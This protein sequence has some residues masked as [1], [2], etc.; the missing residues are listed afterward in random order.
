LGWRP[1]QAGAD[2]KLYFVGD[3]NQELTMTAAI[4]PLLRPRTVGELLD[5]AVRLY[6][7]NFLKFIGIVAV[8]QIPLSLLQLVASLITFNG[9]FELVDSSEVAPSTLSGIASFIGLSSTILLSILGFLLIQGMTTAAL[10]RAIAGSYV[11]EP[12]GIIESYRKIGPA[13]LSLFSTLLLALLLVLAVF[14]WC[15]IPCVGWI[16]GFGMLAF[17]WMVIIPLII[18]V[19]VVEGRTALEAIRRAWDL[20]RRRFWWVLG[21]VFTLFI[22]SLLVVQGPVTVLTY[23]FYFVIGTQFEVTG[24]QLVLQTVIQAIAEMTLSLLYLPLQLTAIALLYFDLRIRTEGFDLMLLAQGGGEWPSHFSEL[25]T[26]APQPQFERW[27]TMAEMGQFALI[28]VGV[29]GLYFAFISLL[30]SLIFAIGFI[31]S[32]YS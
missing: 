8:V 22:F 23:L 14:I 24:W 7:Q 12:I 16:T 17:F 32:A 30:M 28:M 9:F 29:F 11:G 26:G 2:F 25:A 31:A 1:L 10:T 21:F 20:S 15:L 4:L 27:L 6:R 3:N 19:V 18:P 5:Q 13:W